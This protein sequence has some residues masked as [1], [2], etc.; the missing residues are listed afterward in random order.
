MSDTANQKQCAN[1]RAISF[2]E[3]ISTLT[4]ATAA[5]AISI[6]SIRSVFQTLLSRDFD[7]HQ[8]NWWGNERLQGAVRVFNAVLNKMDCKVE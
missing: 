8:Q 4:S 3:N 1:D 5:M 2:Q 6:T 7:I